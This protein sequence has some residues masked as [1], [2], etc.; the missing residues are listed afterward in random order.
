MTIAEL[1]QIEIEEKVKF[2]LLPGGRFVIRGKA[3]RTG[4]SARADRGLPRRDSGAAR[5]ARWR[6]RRNHR[7]HHRY[8]SAEQRDPARKLRELV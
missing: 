8:Q 7:A 1:S 2:K 3:Q 6:W 4:K 5:A